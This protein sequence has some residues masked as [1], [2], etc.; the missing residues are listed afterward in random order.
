MNPVRL[1]VDGYQITLELKKISQFNNA[2]L[3][4]V[5]GTYEGRWFREFLDGDGEGA[6]IHR[7]F[8]PSRKVAVWNH[9]QKQKLI[10]IYG[11]RRAQAEH[12]LDATVE[13]PGLHWTSFNGLRCKLL[14]ENTN[15]RL[16]EESI[17]A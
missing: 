3:V 17:A 9:K 4:Y 7:R 1:E 10:K 16:I 13:I 11:K 2:I 8:Y 15:I 6:E 12:D 14:R 5:N